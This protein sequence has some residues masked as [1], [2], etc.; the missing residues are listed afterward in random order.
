M[1]AVQRVLGSMVFRVLSDVG[2]AGDIVAV[3]FS[4]PE[5]EPSSYEGLS[6]PK[7]DS[8]L[9]GGIAYKWGL[10]TD[11][12]GPDNPRILSPET[13]SSPAAAPASSGSMII[14]SPRQE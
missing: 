10:R 4:T 11:R 7:H 8:A 2:M 6:R 3:L 13:F 9:R 1:E 5:W 12:P 14:D